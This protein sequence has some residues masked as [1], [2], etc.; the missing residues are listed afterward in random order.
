MTKPSPA[1]YR[2]A[3]WPGYNG[4]LKQRGS[5]LIRCPLL[6]PAGMPCQATGNTCL[7]V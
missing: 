2:T 4:A 3:N 5:L 7:Q 6:G 1:R